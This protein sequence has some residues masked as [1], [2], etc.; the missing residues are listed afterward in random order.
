VLAQGS[1]AIAATNGIYYRPRGARYF[2]PKMAFT[3]TSGWRWRRLNLGVM[4]KM[5]SL[6]AEGAN[7][8]ERQ[9]F[10]SRA[11]RHCALLAFPHLMAYRPPAPG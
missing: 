1:T 7:A 4:F 11:L 2:S 10:G 5:C 9:L 8:E 6:T 3:A